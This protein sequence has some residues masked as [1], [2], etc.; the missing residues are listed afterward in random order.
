MLEI[1]MINGDF[2]HV[3][4]LNGDEERHCAITGMLKEHISSSKVLEGLL[5]IPFKLLQNF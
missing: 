3:T 1:M 2:G 4:A 5:F